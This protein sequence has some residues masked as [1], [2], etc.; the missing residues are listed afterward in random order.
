[1]AYNSPHNP[2][3]AESLGLHDHAFLHPN[4]MAA[5]KNCSGESLKKL[6]S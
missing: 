6:K 4:F 3:I 2:K 1:L 5:L